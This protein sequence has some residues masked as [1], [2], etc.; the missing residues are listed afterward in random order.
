[1]TT[2]RRL[3]DCAQILSRCILSYRPNKSRQLVT[4]YPDSFESS[5]YCRN[6][7]LPDSGSVFDDWNLYPHQLLLSRQATCLTVNQYSVQFCPTQRLAH[8]S[9]RFVTVSTDQPGPSGYSF[10]LEGSSDWDNSVFSLLALTTTSPSGH[11]IS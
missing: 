7:S 3:Q 4:R 2:L 6:L 5:L 1:M 10:H 8:V 11:P 9:C